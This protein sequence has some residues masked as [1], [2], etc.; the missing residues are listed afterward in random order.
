MLLSNKILYKDIIP[1]VKHFKL[2]VFVILF[3]LKNVEVNN[4]NPWLKPNLY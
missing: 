2:I 3:D 1:F 4:K